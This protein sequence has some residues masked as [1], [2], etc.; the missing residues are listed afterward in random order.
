MLNVT[1]KENVLAVLLNAIK[2][3]TGRT[4]CS[5]NLFMDNDILQRIFHQ[6][7]ELVYQYTIS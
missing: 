7:F 3:K 1:T 4:I 5:F 2:I 6:K